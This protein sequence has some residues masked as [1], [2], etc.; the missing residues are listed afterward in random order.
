MSKEKIF[1]K[2]VPIVIIFCFF[3][4]RQ[5]KTQATFHFNPASPPVF[6]DGSIADG[7]KVKP[8][9]LYN[10]GVIFINLLTAGAPLSEL[11][12]LFKQGMPHPVSGAVPL[13]SIPKILTFGPW[14]MAPVPGMTT[15]ITLAGPYVVNASS[16]VLQSVKMTFTPGSNIICMDTLKS[17]NVML[18]I[19]N[20]E[21]TFLGGGGFFVKMRSPNVISIE[22]TKMTKVLPTDLPQI[23]HFSYHKASTT[24]ISIKN[25]KF[26]T[27][28]N[29]AMNTKMNNLL[30]FY[31]GFDSKSIE[32][33]NSEITGVN[34]IG[35][36]KSSG[37]FEG[38]K[39]VFVNSKFT[40]AGI[41]NFQNVK[42]GKSHFKDLVFQKIKIISSRIIQIASDTMHFTVEKINM[43]EVEFTVGNGSGNALLPRFLLSLDKIGELYIQSWNVIK[44]FSKYSDNAAPNCLV[45]TAAPIISFTLFDINMPDNFEVNSY[46]S[47]Y[48]KIT[49]LKVENI[50]TTFTKGYF[51]KFG[52]PALQGSSEKR[53]N[54]I[55]VYGEVQVAVFSNIILTQSVTTKT[56]Y[57]FILNAIDEIKITDFKSMGS[58]V[59]SDLDL[60]NSL[61]TVLQ[62]KE[63]LKKINILNSE[64]KSNYFFSTKKNL[65][66]SSCFTIHGKIIDTLVENSFF[67]NN[68][69]PDVNFDNFDIQSVITKLRQVIIKSDLQVETKQKI[70]GISGNGGGFSIFGR[71]MEMQKSKIICKAKSPNL[72]NKVR[73][74]FLTKD[75]EN[76]DYQEVDDFYKFKC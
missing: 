27:P 46:V 14:E 50:K 30:M 10:Q 72:K 29:P 2:F 31:C 26:M 57:I 33:S 20:S 28:P 22:N 43:N 42:G 24:D 48:K 38:T 66:Y 44:V 54:F 25:V 34:V 52:G 7:S 60:K 17:A 1:K 67:E 51:N 55:S 13:T 39:N 73:V 12:L 18:K 3:F 74:Y 61:I 41:F 64:F 5:V 15:M 63:T 19:T 16:L 75:M 56:S 45:H 68:R 21:L 9:P 49:N 23:F 32:I 36:N 70:N 4:F 47:T 69:A 6:P 37:N 53:N 71:S 65:N 40:S 11:N 76:M 58:I 62:T 35:F 59:S 8:Y